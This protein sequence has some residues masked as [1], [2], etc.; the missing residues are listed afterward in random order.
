MIEE[1]ITNQPFKNKS[2]LIPYLLSL[3]LVALVSGGGVYLWQINV[4]NNPKIP[5]NQLIIPT[6]TNV[7]EDTP[8]I[9][10]NE[11]IGWKTYKNEKYGLEFAYPNEFSPIRDMT[12]KGD[13]GIQFAVVSANNEF[14]VAGDSLD[15]SEGR[16]GSTADFQG[17]INNNGVIKLRSM[18]GGPGIA[19]E[20]FI[21]LPK[22]LIKDIFIN[23]NGVEILMVNGKSYDGEMRNAVYG[24]AGDGRYNALINTK[25]TEIPGLIFIAP[26]GYPEDDFLKIVSS[27]KI[28]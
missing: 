4:S 28:E 23:K 25:N 26:A 22:E 18:Y 14:V 19:K 11:T 2:I 21:D 13:T 7:Q 3:I 5:L 24:T 15:Y 9:T 17:Y 8:A 20:H 6:V 10:E 16:S 12:S 1:N 27:I